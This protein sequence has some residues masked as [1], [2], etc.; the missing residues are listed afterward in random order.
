MSER[1]LGNPGMKHTEENQITKTKAFP[2]ATWSTTN[3]AWTD[4]ESKP[5]LRGQRP[6]TNC[7]RHGAA[8]SLERTMKIAQNIS[9]DIVNT[10]LRFEP[11]S[12]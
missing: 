4:P 9:Q 10:G 1:V 3:L 5:L 6:A 7:L 11:R 12:S 8:Y 2:T